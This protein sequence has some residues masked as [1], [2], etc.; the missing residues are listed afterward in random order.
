M[1]H[2][3]VKSCILSVLAFT[4]AIHPSFGGSKVCRVLDSASNLLGQFVFDPA[5]SNAVYLQTKQ[6]YESYVANGNRWSKE[7]FTEIDQVSAICQKCNEPLKG[8]AALPQGQ[9][10]VTA[11][12]S[13]G[14]TL[15]PTNCPSQN[16]KCLPAHLMMLN[17]QKGPYY[18]SDGSPVSM[19]TLWLEG[20]K[21]DCRSWLNS[22]VNIYSEQYKNYM[23]FNE[24]FHKNFS[25]SMTYLAQTAGLL[26]KYKVLQTR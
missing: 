4:W 6:Q 16:G 15:E 9:G 22:K 26:V 14:F 11:D 21:N 5:N 19:V 1:R 12:L 7:V 8:V 20:D 10:K 24:P 25:L 23:I 2:L 18:A 17:E 3:L 13:W